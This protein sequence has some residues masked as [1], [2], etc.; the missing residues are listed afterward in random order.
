MLIG[1]PSSLFFI[2][3]LFLLSFF[4]VLSFSFN[5]G[6]WEPNYG[7]HAMQIRSL[8]HEGFFLFYDARRFDV[9]A[10]GIRVGTMEGFAVRGEEG[11]REGKK[12]WCEGF[13]VGGIAS[14]GEKNENEGSG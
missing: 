14:S 5:L 1:F 13:G 8:S 7:N 12:V 4:V 11:Q 6:R 2:I 9:G 3:V 10:R